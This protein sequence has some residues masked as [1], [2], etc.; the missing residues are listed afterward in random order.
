MLFKD[1]AKR[2]LV[3]MLAGQ[4]SCNCLRGYW[5]QPL[6]HLLQGIRCIG[7]ALINVYWVPE[8]TGNS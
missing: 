3:S 7:N 5:Q 2:L 1:M 8:C 4:P 6:A